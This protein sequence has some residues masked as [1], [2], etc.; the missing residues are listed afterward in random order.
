M[1]YYIIV[2]VAILLDRIVKFLIASKMQPGESIPVLDNIFHITYV[3][4]Q[5]AAFSMM[6]GQ[7]IILIVLPAVVLAAGLVL[8][9]WKR[10]KWSR[11]MLTGIALICGGGIGNLIDRIGQG[12]VVDLFDFRVFPVFNIADIGICVGCGLLLLDVLILDRK[13]SGRDE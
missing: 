4:N 13:Q 2:I 9:F 11:V 10:H 1:I 5:G 6:Q 12:Y 3:Q 7:W 8:L